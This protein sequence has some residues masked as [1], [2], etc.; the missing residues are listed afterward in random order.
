MILQ[1]DRMLHAFLIGIQ[2]KQHCQGISM[3]SR[4]RARPLGS[5]HRG[6][7][8]PGSSTPLRRHLSGRKAMPEDMRLARPQPALTN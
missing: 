8:A 4:P 1:L 2:P 3:G 5:A 7:A 6:Q